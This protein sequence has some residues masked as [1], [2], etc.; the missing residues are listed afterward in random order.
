M[1]GTWRRGEKREK[2]EGR[3]KQRGSRDMSEKS[4]NAIDRESDI[5]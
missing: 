3:K 1:E 4:G 5:E 2:A